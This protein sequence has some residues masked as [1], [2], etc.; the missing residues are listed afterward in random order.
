ME[1]F[2]PGLGGVYVNNIG[3]DKKETTCGVP[4]GS[5]LGPLLWNIAFD[6]FLKEDV[7][8]GV[9][10]ICYTNHTLVVMAVDVIA[11]SRR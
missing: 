4:Q 8:P 1:R 7:P 6:N 11:M 2:L 3:H 10:S 9:S 5:V